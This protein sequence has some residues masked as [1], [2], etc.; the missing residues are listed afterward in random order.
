MGIKSYA[1]STL[2]ELCL[3]SS[4]PNIHTSN[5]PTTMRSGIVYSAVAALCVSAVSA[6]GGYGYNVP[7]SGGSSHSGSFAK[8][9]P[10]V[11]ET[12]TD[13]YASAF[14]DEYSYAYVNP[15]AY[16]DADAYTYDGYYDYYY[17]GYAYAESESTADAD[18]DAYYED[19]YVDTYT[20]ADAD[21]YGDYY[22]KADA[23]S[24]ADGYLTIFK[25][26]HWE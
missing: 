3:R 22:A 19:I 1:L 6:N 21:V 13:T 24:Y 17:D 15:D 12:Y 10:Y 16:A 7:T 18:V 9:T 14:A 26:Y 4:Y 11:A 8:A 2:H 5:Q 20:D 25:K 23:D